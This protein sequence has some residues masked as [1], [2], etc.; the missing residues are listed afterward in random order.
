MEY[1]HIIYEKNGG[2]GLVTINRPE[3][4]NAL[5]LRVFAELKDV[6]QVMDQDKEVHCVVITGKGAM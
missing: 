5:N 3:V 1:Q 4:L 6:F 2:V